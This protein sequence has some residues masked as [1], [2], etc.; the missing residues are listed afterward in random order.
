MIL[1]KLI[2]VI[3][4]TPLMLSDIVLLKWC[5]ECDIIDAQENDRAFIV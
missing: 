5:Y 1:T 2:D 4:M 3:L